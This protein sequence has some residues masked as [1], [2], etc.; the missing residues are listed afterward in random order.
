MKFSYY[1]GC[2]LEVTAKEYDHSARSVCQ[3]LGIELAELP[4][5][6]CCGASSAHSVSRKL[7][8]ALPA[9]T[10]AQAQEAGSDLVTPCPACSNR[11]KRADYAL[12][13]DAPLR[14]ETEELLGFTYTGTVRIY[15]LLEAIV[16]FF[17][18]PEIARRVKKPLNGLKVVCYYGCLLVRPPE[19][20]NFDRPENP[21]TMDNLMAALGAEVQNWSYKTECCGA[22]QGIVN[23]AYSA[24][25]V[26]T[27]LTMAAE[28]GAQALVVSCPLCQATLEMRRNPELAL[29][30]FYFT[31][32]LELA[33]GV[34]EENIWLSKHL[35]DPRPLLRRLAAAG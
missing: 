33:L 3:L 32:L 25:L 31:E 4:D 18:P 1:P 2:S 6:S 19:V 21:V 10:I 24:H 8:V 7:A 29:P 22:H 35:V 23:R 12:R 27:L 20:A 15:S 16:N 30:S 11:L 14:R 17:A 28:A 9:R 13:H 34:P 26:N 5:W